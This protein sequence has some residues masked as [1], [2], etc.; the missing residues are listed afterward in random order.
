MVTCVRPQGLTVAA[1]S[2]IVC[3]RRKHVAN[4]RLVLEAFLL[5]AHGADDAL[6]HVTALEDALL[7]QRMR[8]ELLALGVLGPL[9]S[10]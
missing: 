10:R 7:L 9:L 3:L 8:G 1:T 4:R 2:C 6:H 5:P